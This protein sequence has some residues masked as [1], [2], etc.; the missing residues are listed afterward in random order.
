MT[1]SNSSLSCSKVELWAE[2]QGL[3][4]AAV[5]HLARI[6][7][8]A[9]L[10]QARKSTADDI[11]TLSSTC[12]KLNSMHLESLLFMWRMRESVINW[13]LMAE[14]FKLDSGSMSMI[15]ISKMLAIKVNIN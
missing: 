13:S 8:A 7:K 6:S 2:K 11:A 10:L 14:I 12:L 5:C 3:E 1:S 15:N 4:L 9:H